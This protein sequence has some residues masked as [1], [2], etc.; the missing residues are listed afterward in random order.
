MLNHDR[1][2]IDQREDASRVS[3]DTLTDWQRVKTNFTDVALAQLE[4]R[5][6]S[7]G[8]TLERDAILFHL[9]K[10]IK[11]VHTHFVIILNLQLLL[12]QF[13]DA[14]FKIAQP[15]LRVNGR[16]FEE[17]DENEEGQQLPSILSVELNVIDRP[18]RS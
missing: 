7:S 18:V 5:I 12:S 16:N 10:V 4:L 1:S 3:V 15:N 6:A 2:D 11:R 8:L 13:I 14:T 17:L 9:K